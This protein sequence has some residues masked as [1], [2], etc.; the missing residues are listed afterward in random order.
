MLC[1]SSM[2][3]LTLTFSKDMLRE[4]EVVVLPK[5]QFL[6]LVERAEGAVNEKDV[7]RWSREARLLKRARKLPLLHSVRSL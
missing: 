3:K 5:K 1:Y 4:R 2:S 6:S 7:L